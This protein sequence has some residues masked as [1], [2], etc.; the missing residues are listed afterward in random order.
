M[1]ILNARHVFA[2]PA[3]ASTV[4]N[5]VSVISGVGLAYF[6][7]PQ[8]N[9]LEPHFTERALHGVSIG[10]LIGGVAQLLIQLP[11]LWRQGFRPGWVWNLKDPHLCEVLRL[12]VPSVISGSAVQVNVLV[13]GIFASMVN[14]GISWLNCAFRL[15]Q[16]PIGVFGVAIATVTLPAVSVLKARQDMTG[17]GKALQD[18]LRLTFFLTLPAATGLAVLAHPIIQVIYEHGRFS[19]SDTAATAM[20]LQ[21]YALGLV[22]YSAIKV[23]T[24]CFY[25]L[26]EAKAPLRVSLWGMGVN[27]ILNGIFFFTLGWGHVGLAFSTSLLAVINFSQLLAMMARRVHLGAPK[28]WFVYAIRLILATLAM[29]IVAT[30]TLYLYPSSPLLYEQMIR[31]IFAILLSV[32]TFFSITILLQMKEPQ[33]L[34]SVIRIKA[35]KTV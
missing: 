26:G 17:F 25:A 16:F 12:M 13:N 10:V 7:D 30:L 9:W 19:A 3:S 32:L 35:K 8:E 22:G 18:A 34:F 11:S 15:M 31:L 29:A 27:V 28:V 21:A 14:G 4:F 2:L 6:F 20:A 33:N 5:I 1:G 24:P 23:L